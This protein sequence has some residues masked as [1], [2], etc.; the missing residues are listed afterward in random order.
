MQM[1]LLRFAAR[2]M[3]QLV[4]PG[5]WAG[6]TGHRAGGNHRRRRGRPVRDGIERGVALGQPAAG[7][8]RVL[9]PHRVRTVVGL[10][11]R[12]RLRVRKAAVR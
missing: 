3:Q 10:D 1:R 2:M 4:R 12:V 5:S 7:R 6:R 8:V 11:L 9:E